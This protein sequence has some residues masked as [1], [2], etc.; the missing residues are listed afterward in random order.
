MFWNLICDIHA[1]TRTDESPILDA[2]KQDFERNEAVIRWVAA[3]LQ[4]SLPV[5]GAN[6]AAARTT[7]TRTITTTLLE[8]RHHQ[9]N[10][11]H[12]NY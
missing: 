8:A 4:W 5:L 10:Q 2:D 3:A 12:D 11:N 7:T 9:H 6:L 1:P